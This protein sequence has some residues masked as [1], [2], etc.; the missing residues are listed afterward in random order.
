MNK[1]AATQI[2]LASLLIISFP[3]IILA[4]VA[5]YPSAY[6][7]P[8]FRNYLSETI[9][10][11]RIEGGH[12]AADFTKI[13]VTQKFR[14]LGRNNVEKVLDIAA[15]AMPNTH[16]AIF[17]HDKRIQQD[18]AETKAL[19]AQQAQ[20]RTKNAEATGAFNYLPHSNGMT[21]YF[22]DGL[23]VEIT[24]EEM[25]DIT[26][27]S[28]TSHKFNMVYNDDRLLIGYDSSLTDNMGN[29]SLLSWE[30][31]YTA[32]S[33][34]YGS[35]TTNANKHFASTKTV[36][37]DKAGNI[38]ST[39]WNAPSY[40]GKLLRAFSQQ[41]E[42]QVF[43]EEAFT[44]TQ[45]FTRTNI[46]Y[47]AGSNIKAT[48]YDEEGIDDDGYSYTLTRENITY[49]LNDVAGYQ[50]VMN[51]VIE[52]SNVTYISDVVNTYQDVDKKF[53]EDIEETLHRLQESVVTTTVKNKDGSSRTD[54]T[55][56]KYTYD[57]LLDT[58]TS[59]SGHTEFFGDEGTDAFG[60]RKNTFEG[61]S[62]IEYEIL[63][64]R[65][66]VKNIHTETRYTNPNDGA[67]ISTIIQDTAYTN[68]LKNNLLRL[69]STSE[70]SVTRLL[71]D[72]TEGVFNGVE[73]IAGSHPEI[74]SIVTTYTYD[75][76]GNLLRVD[77]SGTHTGYV[78]GANGWQDPFNRAVTITYKDISDNHGKVG[79]QS[80][81]EVPIVEKSLN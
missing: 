26:G 64:D 4:E 57:P 69:L 16:S 50:E 11:G 61:S 58:L 78:L 66:M 72:E 1:K 79:L 7:D 10:N 48:S 76:L 43:G 53:G 28:T 18:A 25:V 41:I 21:E 2:F 49:D 19:I 36:E 62:D 40:E 12:T 81:D 73:Y 22:K 74:E 77:G 35:D 33:V 71:A 14:I 13:D 80:R 27:L 60:G 45:S 46:Q 29:I 59:A 24:G 31:A 67:Q 3:A 23:V 42:H 65:A 38:T 56:T 37:T 20:L 75:D 30:A 17:E 70:N 54:I 63:F 55:T 52:G 6:M 32:D 5:D 68:G 47:N 8:G 9:V 51:K 15:N 44:T 34:F 39:T